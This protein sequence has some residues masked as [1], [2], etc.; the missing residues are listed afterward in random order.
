[1]KSMNEEDEPMTKEEEEFL[2]QAAAEQ[3]KLVDEMWASGA[4]NISKEERMR[5]FAEQQ[6]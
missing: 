6:A 4:M 2:T 3:Q 1:M 5:R